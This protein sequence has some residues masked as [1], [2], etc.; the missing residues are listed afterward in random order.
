MSTRNKRDVA[1]QA[2]NVV[3]ALFQVGATVAAS[4]KIQ[5]VVDEGPPSLVEPAGYAFAIW[6]LIFALSLVYAVYQMLPA[7]HDKELLLRIGPFTAGAFACTGL[8]S[9]FVPERQFVLAQAMLLA[10][11][12]CLAVAYIRLARDA[13]GRVLSGGERWLVA[14]SLGPFFGWITATNAV[15]LTSEADRLGVVGSGGAGET[16]LGAA[17]LLLGG[18]LA[19]AAVLAGKDGPPQGYLAYAATVLWALIGVVANQYDASLVTTGAAIVAAVSIALVLFFGV[20]RGGRPRR[21]AGGTVR[22]GAA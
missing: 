14:L 3:A 6:A 15:S 7:N 4:A 11:F 19:A 16:L 13:R 2:A 10:I 5:E 1:R 8:W 22:S 20:L 12:A 21:A 17:L 18:L 9:I